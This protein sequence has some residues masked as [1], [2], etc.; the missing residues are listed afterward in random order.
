M[1]S[2]DGRTALHYAAY[3]GVKPEYVESL[4][5]HGAD[6]SATDAEGHT[7]LDLAKQKNRTKVVAVL[8]SAVG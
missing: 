8:E 3:Q 4:L 6:P 2:T 5:N 1:T 7:A